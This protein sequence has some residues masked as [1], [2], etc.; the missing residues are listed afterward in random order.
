M[1]DEKKWHELIQA[2]D[3]AYFKGDCATRSRL[4][5]YRYG[6]LEVMANDEWAPIRTG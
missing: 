3:E 4:M 1:I 2:E 5:Q 6:T